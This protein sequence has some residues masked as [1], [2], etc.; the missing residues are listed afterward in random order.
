[1]EAHKLAQAHAHSVGHVC[2]STHALLLPRHPSF[3]RV[4]QEKKK[5]LVRATNSTMPGEEEG[6]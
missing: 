4:E 2:R 3:S 6:L 1:M 5:L